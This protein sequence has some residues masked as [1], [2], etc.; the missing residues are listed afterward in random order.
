LAETY[1]KHINTKYSDK[2]LPPELTS[3]CS[4]SAFRKQSLYRKANRKLSFVAEL[5]MLILT[6]VV[7]TTNG[8]AKLD[9]LLQDTPFTPTTI[10]LLFFGAIGLIQLIISTPIAYIQNFQIEARFGFNTQTTP[11]FIADRIKE[12]LISAVIGGILLYII[13]TLHQI[14]AQW[15]WVIAW[16]SIAS[17]SILIS[18]FYTSL[19]V[20]I[21]N[22][23]SP[24]EAGPL[25]EGIEAFGKKTRFSIQNVYVIDGSK[26][27]TKANA[28]FTGWGRRKKIVLY[29][30]LIQQ[31]NQPEILAVLAH[32]LGHY[33]HRH[34]IK[35][36]LIG[37]VQ[38]GFTLFLLSLSLDYPYFCSA[39]G[40]QNQNFH[41][42]LLA[43]GLLYSPLSYLQGIASNYYSRRNEIQADNFASTHQLGEPLISALQKLSLE[44]LSNL[45]P[46]PWY[47][48]VHYSHPPILQRIRNI[49]KTG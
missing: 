22:K 18:V 5:L 38:M 30:T 19:I 48:N 47:V 2:K 41:I 34:V 31:L 49:R 23:L 27:S 12:A 37:V 25:R 39:L 10:S 14:F 9:N 11:L 4:P 28:Y 6:L 16:V 3:F 24:L 40:V 8:F 21:F 36:M 29:D 33:T 20:P 46:H 1:L 26:R 35:G 44:S 43:F 32:E 45:N 7:L 17:I 15:F 42:G 13:A